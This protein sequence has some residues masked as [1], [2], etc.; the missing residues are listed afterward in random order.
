MR[1]WNASKTRRRRV[2]AKGADNH[3]QMTRTGVQQDVDLED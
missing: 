1:T 2:L 3:R